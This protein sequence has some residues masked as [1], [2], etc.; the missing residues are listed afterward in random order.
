[1]FCFFFSIRSLNLYCLFQVASWLLHPRIGGSGVISGGLI[2][3]K[4]PT[5]QSAQ[6]AASYHV[7][8]IFSTTTCWQAAAPPKIISPKA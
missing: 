6:V 3:F 2:T 8:S 7:E 5:Q 4:I 1:M